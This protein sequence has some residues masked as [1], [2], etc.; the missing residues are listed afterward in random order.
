MMKKLLCA[1]CA[2]ALFALSGCSLAK[3]D[4]ADPGVDILVGAFVSSDGIG[5]PGRDGPVEAVKTESGWEIP[6]AEGVWVYVLPLYE[7]D[8]LRFEP[9]ADPRVE[10]GGVGAHVDGGMKWRADLALWNT[11]E[12]VVLHFNPLYLR[13]D[14][15]LYA[16]P[17]IGLVV[18][19]E[20]VGQGGGWN[21]SESS[22]APLVAGSDGNWTTSVEIFYEVTVPARH[23]VL[24]RMDEENRELSRQEYLPGE[25][26]EEYAPDCAWLLLE[27]HLVDGTV[28]RQVFGPGDGSLTTLL[29]EVGGL[30]RRSAMS[31]NWN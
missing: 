30:C 5:Y 16:K 11:T 17:S 2:L 28:E 15:T 7:T 19:T 13:G 27:K 21:C 8:C 6:G 24:C 3:A 20:L 31:L 14:G 9:S 18:D 4:S 26:P 22:L 25:L 23:Y 29:P 1:L 10:M 12:E